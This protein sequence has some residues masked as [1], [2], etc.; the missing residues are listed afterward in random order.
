MADSDKVE[1]DAVK[2]RSAFDELQAVGATSNAISQLKQLH[3]DAEC[4]AVMQE[5]AASELRC[6]RLAEALRAGTA[7]DMVRT[8]VRRSH[9]TR[10]QVEAEVS[11]ALDAAAARGISHMSFGEPA[12]RPWW[13]R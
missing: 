13:K 7:V 5:M 6:R 9:M 12:Y 1:P 8:A 10:E 4:V 2:D 3:G 11:A